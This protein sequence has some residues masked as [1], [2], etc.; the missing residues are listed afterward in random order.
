MKTILKNEHITVKETGRNYDFIATIENN[1]DA[2]IVITFTSDYEYIEPIK[3]APQDWIGI[4]ASDEGYA[5][6][7]ALMERKY[8]TEV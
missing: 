8:K 3:I 6:I 4:E 2:Q 5:T 1:T 7:V